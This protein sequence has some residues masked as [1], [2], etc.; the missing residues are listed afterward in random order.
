MSVIQFFS[1]EHDFR[2]SIALDFPV[3]IFATSAKPDSPEY[4]EKEA[5]A[6]RIIREHLT[7]SPTAHIETDHIGIY[8]KK[9]ILSVTLDPTTRYT[10]Q[11]H[12]TVWDFMTP[13]NKSLILRMRDPV[14]LSPTSIPPVIELLSYH[15]PAKARPVSVCPISLEDFAKIEIFLKNA[16]I[17]WDNAS[18]KYDEIA[19][20]NLSPQEAFFYSGITELIA[21]ESCETVTIPADTSDTSPLQKTQLPSQIY[22]KNEAQQGCMSHFFVKQ[23]TAISMVVSSHH[24]SLAW[25]IHTSRWR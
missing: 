14:T 10:M 15:A 3:P 25:S 23:M 16:D 2:S 19:S 7:L 17:S 12:D 8:D 24:S 1:P 13:E 6:Q 21:R 9:I 20:K 18:P 22:S 4:R 5:E 11:Y